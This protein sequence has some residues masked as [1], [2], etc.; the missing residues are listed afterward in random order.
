MHDDKKIELFERA[1]I[2]S[3]VAKLSIPM[4]LSSLVE[5]PFTAIIDRRGML[6]M[7]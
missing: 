1:S 3:A 4:I 2:P 6:P 7:H 5:L